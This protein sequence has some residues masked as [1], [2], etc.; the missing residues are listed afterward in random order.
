MTPTTD[1]DEPI[2]IPKEMM[3]KATKAVFHQVL[4]LL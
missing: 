1:V 2:K 3:E 4:S